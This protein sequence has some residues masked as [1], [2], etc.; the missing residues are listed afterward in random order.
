MYLRKK[1]QYWILDN[2]D[3]WTFLKN[4]YISL[5]SLILYYFVREFSLCYVSYK[6]HW[7]WNIIIIVKVNSLVTMC[8]LIFFIEFLQWITTEWVTLLIS[9]HVF[10]YKISCLQMMWHILKKSIFVGCNI[11]FYDFKSKQ[12]CSSIFYHL[13]HH[14]WNHSYV[15]WEILQVMTVYFYK[16]A[17]IHILKEDFLCIFTISDHSLVVFW[18]R[19]RLDRGHSINSVNLLLLPKSSNFVHIMTTIIFNTICALNVYNSIQNYLCT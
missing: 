19:K 15:F 14:K 16:S 5:N 13:L 1:L 12:F 18:P 2:F 10:S 11:S 9:S 3:N 6:N 8:G 17:H 4:V 7:M